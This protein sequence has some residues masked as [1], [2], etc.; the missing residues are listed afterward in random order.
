MTTDADE[1]TTGL[2][3]AQIERLAL[4]IEECGEVIQA[5][6]K[7]LR[8]GFES[9]NPYNRSSTKHTT[10]REA[11]AKELGQLKLAV[12][13]LEAGKDVTAFA[14]SEAFSEKLHSIKRWLHFNKGLVP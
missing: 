3:P 14:M 12:H 5:A 6:T 8:H 2:T 10:N 4:L 1:F 11:L 13:L 9:T 7:I